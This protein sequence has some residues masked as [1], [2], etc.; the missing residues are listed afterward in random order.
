M[1]KSTISKLLALVLIVVIGSCTTLYSQTPEELFQ[2]GMIKEEGEG[3]LLEAIDIYNE[4]VDNS[5]ADRSLRAKALLQ[6]GLCY[7]KLGQTEAINSYQKLITDFADQEEIVAI[8]KKQLS[9]LGSNNPVIAP[10]GIVARQIWSPAEDCYNASPD[11]RYITYIDWNRIELCVKDLKTGATWDLTN[12]GT[13]QPVSQFPDNS[14]W[15]PDS[16][17]VVFFWYVGDTTELHIINRDGSDDRILSRDYK[18][19]TPWPVEW[20]HNS[21]DFLAFRAANDEEVAMN[22]VS[23]IVSVSSKD[24]STKVIRSIGDFRP[25]GN[26]SLSPDGRYIV[27]AK[28]QEKD[29]EKNDIF[30]VAAD[31]SFE[32]RLVRNR[33][34]DVD[35]RWLPDGSGI[36][37][38]SDRVGTNDLY[39]LALMNGLPDGEPEILKADLGDEMYILGISENNSLL[40]VTKFERTDVFKG[41]VDF[42][43]GELISGPERISDMESQRNIKPMWSPDGRYIAYL[44][45]TPM[46][47]K[48]LGNRFIY[49]IH[50]SK[51]GEN[52]R[53]ETDLYG[54]IR[55][56]WN[57][58]QWS[59]DGKYILTQARTEDTLQGF[60]LV[61]VKNAESSPVYVKKKDFYNH[62]PYAIGHF[63]TFSKDGKDIFYLSEDKKTIIRRNLESKQEKTI[64]ES[65]DPILQYL[66]SPDESKIALGYWNCG[67]KAL[68]LVPTAGGKV[69]Q[70]MEALENEPPYLVA[71]SND[72][73]HIIFES[74]KYWDIESHAIYTVPATGGEPEQIFQTKNLV[75]KGEV[76]DMDVHPDGKQ[77]VLGIQVGKGLEVWELENIFK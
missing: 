54:Q 1:K 30:I 55:N 40:Y 49:I 28:Q 51:T 76:M 65:E 71:W 23:Q 16:K 61:D 70:L 27:Y 36:I 6:V 10:A 62:S 3:S 21:E 8:G 56:Y 15:S 11:G 38:I 59:P 29:S 17:E 13:W 2:K 18:L 22:Y 42:S 72:S 46:W 9:Y 44:E 48:N 24:G 53:I 37:F 4:V 47:D 75:S 66:V 73:K 60:F 63:P 32:R 68:Y 31:G 67:E 33:E 43:T 50:D 74:G 45:A 69:Q 14:I 58:S 41:N 12:T 20:P 77:I 34:N 35:A 19:V 52:K 7:E 39:R 57:K 5:S 64:H 25:D 26:M